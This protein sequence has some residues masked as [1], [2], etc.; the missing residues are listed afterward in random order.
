MEYWWIDTLLLEIV[1]LWGIYIGVI[2]GIKKA[3]EMF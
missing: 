3:Q 1:F 2:I